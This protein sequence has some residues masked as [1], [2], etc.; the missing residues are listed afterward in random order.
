MLLATPT[1]LRS[2]LLIQI[3][4]RVLLT[5]M[6]VGIQPKYDCGK[7]WTLVTFLS[8]LSKEPEI[9]QLSLKRKPP[10]RK[11]H[12]QTVVHSGSQ[13]IGCRDTSMTFSRGGVTKTYH[14]ILAF[15]KKATFTKRK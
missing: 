15:P 5:S 1:V 6:A 7:F 11:P 9:N 10:P 4:S 8:D 2:C 14:K 12:I 3:R 13:G